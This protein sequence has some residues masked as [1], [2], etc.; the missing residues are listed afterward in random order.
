[1]YLKTQQVNPFNFFYKTILELINY[2]N[3][4]GIKL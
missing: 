3:I 4:I 1:M 2:M